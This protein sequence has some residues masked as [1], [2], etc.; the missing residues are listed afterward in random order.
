MIHWQPV[1]GSGSP[2]GRREGGKGRGRQWKSVGLGPARGQREDTHR[3]AKIRGREGKDKPR[4][5][6]SKKGQRGEAGLSQPGNGGRGAE[7]EKSGRSSQEKARSQRW[8][9]RSRSLGIAD[10]ED[11]G[12]GWERDAGDQKE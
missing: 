5:P 7:R 11:W 10:L 12:G 2:T 3:A 1:A 9:W 6:N 4:Q 8:R